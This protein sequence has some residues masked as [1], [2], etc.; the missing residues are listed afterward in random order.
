[1]MALKIFI[2]FVF[3]LVEAVAIE[4]ILSTYVDESRASD[5]E[6]PCRAETKFITERL[7]F[8]PKLFDF[9]GSGYKH[10]Q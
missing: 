3:P 4:L 6:L 7:L 5:V 1:M 10:H 8:S 9:G 2:P